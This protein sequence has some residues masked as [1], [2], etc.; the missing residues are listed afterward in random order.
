MVTQHLA[1]NS[2]PMTVKSVVENSVQVYP[3]GS[4]AYLGY[5]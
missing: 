5:A 4:T 2:V 3:K 1:T